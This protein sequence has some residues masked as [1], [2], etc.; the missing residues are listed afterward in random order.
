MI[1]AN[2]AVVLVA[3]ATCV[4][5]ACGPLRS[6]TPQRKGQATVVLLPESDGTVG[7]AV[8]SNSAGAVELGTARASTL[9]VAGQPPESVT[10]MP[11]ADVGRLFGAALTAQPPAP[12]RFTLYFQFD[13]E[14]LT[15]E[16][17]KLVS[18]VQQ[19]LKAYPA[20]QVTVT[21][22]TDTVGSAESNVELGLRRANVVRSYLIDAGLDAAGINVTSH[23][24]AALLVPTA[25]E[26]A[27]PQNR[28]VDITVR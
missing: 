6:P 20:P 10:E 5:L 22:H 21:G 11:D 16:S 1:C 12:A 4:Q 23:G 24:E 17:R 18:G 15:E 26:I 8:V 14:E 3:V 7:R 19:A 13:S 25:D 9:I 28:R 2:R 27:E